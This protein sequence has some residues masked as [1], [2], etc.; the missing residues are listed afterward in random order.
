MKKAEVYNQVINV[1]WTVL[2]FIPI[3]QYWIPNY[4]RTDFFVS[5]GLSLS[6]F[7][8]PTHYFKF[9]HISTNRKVYER[10]GIKWIQ[11]CTQN[12]L[13]VGNFIRNRDPGFRHIRNIK[14]LGRFKSQINIYEKYHLACFI[15]FLITFCLA[16]KQ[17]AYASLIYIGLANVIYNVFPLL[18]QQYNK[19]RLHLIV[20]E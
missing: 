4:H 13:F 5:L 10:L 8:I 19:T 15:F 3:L 6:T 11:A 1:F 20:L 14:D 9:L 7:F 12:G 16:M 2:C 17:N 18:I